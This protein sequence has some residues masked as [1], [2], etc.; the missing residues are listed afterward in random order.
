MHVPIVRVAFLPDY[1]DAN[2][3]QA[4]LA[5][6][7]ERCGV[8]VTGGRDPVGLQRLLPLVSAAREHDRPDVLHLHW[9]SPYSVSPQLWKTLAKSARFLA[10]LGVVKRSGMKLVWTAHNL[11]HH[12][13]YH[14]RL[15]LLARRRLARLADAIIVHC[16]AARRSVMRAYALPDAA[17]EKVFVVPHASY[18]GTYP[19]VVGRSEA[20]ATVGVGDEDRVFLFLGKLRT[21]KGLGTLVSAFR[22][23]S[24]GAAAKLIIAGRPE[25]PSAIRRVE[26]ARNGDPRIILHPRFVPDDHIQMYMNA[27][28][29]VVLPF[30]DVL[31]SGSVL[32]AMSF[33]KPIIAPSIGCIP[34]VASGGGAFLYDA[35]G[36]KGLK[37]C[38][39][40][41]VA[42]SAQS[43]H[44]MGQASHRTAVGLTWS[45]MASRTRRV[46]EYAL[47][48]GPGAER[49]G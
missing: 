43:L 28:D 30:T 35:D 16:A 2:P 36:E 26:Q 4:C 20:R 19:N 42:T 11:L 49:R 1:S 33:G 9:S 48:A 14:A 39:R 17:T 37:S 40:E 38:L 6:A 3:Y 47:R 10:E 21:Y 24:P 13:R 45:E 34:E 25:S 15:E 32:L 27:A 18:I 31:T 7:L 5:R 22:E 8:V 41:A 29:V 12:E 23:V 46:Y 44:A